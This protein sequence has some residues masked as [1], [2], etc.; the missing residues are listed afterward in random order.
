VTYDISI[1]GFLQATMPGM[2]T[3]LTQERLA[4]LK[5]IARLNEEN[6]KLR[7]DL[8]LARKVLEQHAMCKN[9]FSYDECDYCG[10]YYERPEHRPDCEWLR[11]MGRAGT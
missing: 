4:T 2:A 6:E 9:G 7:A 3:A 11:A 10:A 5:E 1:V 8:A